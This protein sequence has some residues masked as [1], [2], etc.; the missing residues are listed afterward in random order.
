MT[1]FQVPTR[2]D[3]N[4]TNQAIFDKLEK[5]LGFVPN[6]YATF[7]YNDTALPDYLQLQNRK[8]TLKAK[9]REVI[10]LV[11]SQVN[12][13][14]YCLAAHTA[15]G[16]M[17]GFTDEQIL[18]I[19]TGK[20]GFDEKLDALAAYVKSAVE[21]PIGA[22]IPGTQGNENG[23]DKIIGVVKDFNVVSF[24][25]EIPPYIIAY[26]ENS[27]HDHL[28]IDISGQKLSTILPMVE[29]I[30]KEIYPDNPFNYKLID[31]ELMRKHEEDT[32]FLRMIISFTIASVLISCF[33]LF[34][35]AAFTVLQRTKEIGIRKVLGAS[36][37]SILVLL[38]NDFVKLISI[39][40]IL[41]IPITNYFM[42]EWLQQF[43]YKTEIHWW[44]YALPG[45][46][47]LLI[48]LLT[49][50]GHTLKAA[51]QNPVDSL[52]YE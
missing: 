26:N 39:G 6:L 20:A 31:D 32:L 18:E 50:S 45:L 48:A 28:L 19:R 52:R 34:G 25:Q 35:I 16:K 29:K 30:W 4:A 10:N 5:N 49:I 3:V 33:G 41:A 40:F 27:D 1:N 13:C 24:K 15:L 43:A 44:M 14:E 12:E 36:F 7:T 51:R 38:S 23:P 46:L 2:Q 17:N 8:S 22:T 47:V 9:E 42:G 21:N 37:S 11:V